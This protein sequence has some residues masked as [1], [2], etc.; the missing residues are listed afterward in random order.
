MEKVKLTSAQIDTINKALDHYGDVDY[1]VKMHFKLMNRGDEWSIWKELNNLSPVALNHALKYGY[2]IKDEPLDKFTEIKAAIK[3]LNDRG[4]KNE[5]ILFTKENYPNMLLENFETQALHGIDYDDL[6]NL[7]Y[8]GE[9]PQNI[10]ADEMQKEDQVNLQPA[11]YEAM[12][13][14]AVDTNDK[15]WFEELVKKSKGDVAE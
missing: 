7:M 12:L 14:F 2:E 13:L 8:S 1:L 6:F 3:H 9:H 5:D 15:A 11:D 4:F 10:L